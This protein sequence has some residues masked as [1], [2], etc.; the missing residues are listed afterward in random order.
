MFNLLSHLARDYGL[1]KIRTMYLLL[2]G[3]FVPAMHI[4]ITNMGGHGL[5]LPQNIISLMVIAALILLVS[6]NFRNKQFKFSPGIGLFM[7]GCLLLMLPVLWTSSSVW[8]ANALPVVLAFGVAALLYLALLQVSLSRRQK[9]FWLSLIVISAVI[10]ASLAL[11]QM[12]VFDANNWMEFPVGQ[13]RAYGN[14]QQSNLLGS[15]L[16]SGFGIALYLL[17]APPMGGHC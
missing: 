3:F 9:R 6:I 10:E 16:A 12:F 13:S 1:R 7:F 2:I 11:L 14:F 8:R 4:Y 17:H 15:F 5:G